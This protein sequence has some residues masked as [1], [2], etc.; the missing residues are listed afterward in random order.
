MYF[1]RSDFFFFL[2]KVL[3]KEMMGSRVK[4]FY[5]EN[6]LLMMNLKEKWVLKNI[7]HIWAFFL[8]YP[9]FVYLCKESYSL[10]LPEN[11]GGSQRTEAFS[12]S[13]SLLSII[14]S[15]FPYFSDGTAFC[16][17]LI[18][19]YHFICRTVIKK[20]LK[21]ERKKICIFALNGDKNSF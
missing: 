5:W 3:S 18:T 12:G 21:K 10:M 14:L 7:Y 2:E 6:M 13:R 20:V 19:R 16:R 1:V 9:V 15:S 8:W 11:K 4:L 17:K